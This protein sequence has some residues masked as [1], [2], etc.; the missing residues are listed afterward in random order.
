MA[1]LNAQQAKRAANP[2]TLSPADPAGDSWAN[3]GAEA[4]LVE[5][6]GT[7][8]VTIT[9]STYKQVDGLD[10]ADLQVA[11]PAGETHLLGPFPT[12]VYNDPD[13]NAQVSYSSTSGVKVALVE[14]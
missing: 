6:T 11:V 12:D 4:L 9:F 13:G 10:V 2:L 5:N 3:T 7:A 1:L 14:V 8:S